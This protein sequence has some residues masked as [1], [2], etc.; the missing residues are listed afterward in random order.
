MSHL[1]PELQ[2]LKEDLSEMMLLVSK[3]LEKSKLAILENDV[4]L[5]KEVVD[6]DLR[7]NAM[8]LKLDRDCENILALYNPVAIDLRFVISSLK[9]NHDLERIGDNAEG[10]AKYIVSV[11]GEFDQQ[12]I[13]SLNVEDMFN[14]AIS[15]ME[16][17]TEAFENEDTQLARIIFK[18]DQFLNENNAMATDIAINH[19]KGNYE[20]PKQLLFLLSSIRKL[21]RIG[22][23]IK[24]L[25]EE[26]I[27]HIEAKVLKHRKKIK[28]TQ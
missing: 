27:F 20:H 1:E 21:E 15:M 28:S 12:L 19:I 16:D 23:L 14:N 22:D 9:I 26:L 25:A 7:V 13:Q 10:I 5:A 24:N 4:S 8:E 11:K 3:Q 6:N 2:L 18:K 17:L